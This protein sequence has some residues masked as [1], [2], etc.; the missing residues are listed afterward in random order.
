MPDLER[1]GSG[2]PTTTVSCSQVVDYEKFMAF[3][4]QP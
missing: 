1:I 3:L 4:M 2:P